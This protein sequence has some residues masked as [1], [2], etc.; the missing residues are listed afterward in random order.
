MAKPAIPLPF[1]LQ[2]IPQPVPVRENEIPMNAVFGFVPGNQNDMR[3]GNIGYDTLQP[4]RRDSV[5]F[6]NLRRGK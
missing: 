1:T 6:E 4:P 5:R 3:K 2:Q